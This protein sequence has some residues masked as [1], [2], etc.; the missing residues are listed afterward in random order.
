MENTLAY[1]GAD[2][3][4][5]MKRFVLQTQSLPMKEHFLVMFS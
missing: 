5:I 1:Y 2:L 3:V 4:M